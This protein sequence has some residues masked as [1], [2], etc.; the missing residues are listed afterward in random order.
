MEVGDR[1]IVAPKQKNRFPVETV[2]CLHVLAR[3]G[4]KSD[5]GQL[6]MNHLQTDQ[7]VIDSFEKRTA[8]IH[9]IDLEA[10]RADSIHEM[11]Q[12][13]F[14]TPPMLE[15]GVNQVH[16]QDT[17]HLHLLGVGVIQQ[18]DV[19]NDLGRSRVWGGLE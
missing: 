12:D 13:L 5:G 16:P 2:L 8:E 4:K 3:G 19:E 9:H 6:K 7:T 15:C 18:T 11:G 14:R 10:A 17:Q 1:P